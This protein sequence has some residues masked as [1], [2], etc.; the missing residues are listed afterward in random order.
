MQ[1]LTPV[2]KHN[3]RETLIKYD[4]IDDKLHIKI[5]FRKI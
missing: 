1:N 2:S 4:K 5:T 3:V